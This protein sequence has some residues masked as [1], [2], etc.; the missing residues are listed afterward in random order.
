MAQAG[1]KPKAADLSIVGGANYV[2][3][4]TRKALEKRPKPK[5][6]PFS[7]PRGL[8]AAQKTHWKSL[9]KALAP[10]GTYTEHD[11]DAIV[12]LVEAKATVLTL[13]ADV[14]ENGVTFEGAFTETEKADGTILRKQ[15]SRKVNP[16]VSALDRAEKHFNNLLYEHGLTPLGRV[17]LGISPDGGGPLDEIEDDDDSAAKYF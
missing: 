4:K 5:K 9:E 11:Q 10:R 15:G 1:R 6:F 7:M 3:K 16:A 13:R 12:A 8:T 17:K 14:R 2:D